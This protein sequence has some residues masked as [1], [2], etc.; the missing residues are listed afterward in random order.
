MATSKKPAEY[1]VTASNGRVYRITAADDGQAHQLAGWIEDRI[2]AGDDDLA[3]DV[4]PPLNTQVL[5]PA[6]PDIEGADY[7]NTGGLEG[8]VSGEGE[9][10][11]DRSGVIGGIDSF[12]RGATRTAYGN[13]ADEIAAGIDAVLPISRLTGQPVNSIWDGSSLSDAYEHNLNLQRQIDEADDTQHPVMS[14]TGKVGGA[15]L[16]AIGAGKLLKAGA[17][18]VAPMLGKTAIGPVAAAEAYQLAHPVKAA[19]IAGGA[20]GGLSGAFGGSGEGEDAATRIDNAQR[21]GATGLMFGSALAPVAVSLAPA[22]ARYANV[23]FGRMPER[24]ATQ[25]LI[26]ALQRDGYDITSPTGVKALRDE[27]GAYLGKP[28]S[29]ADI[30]IATRSRAGVG[31]RSPSNVQNK[32]VDLV[33]ARQAGQNIRL[34]SDIRATVAPRTDVHALDEALV[35]AREEEALPLRDRAL[36][37]TGGGF[38]DPLVPRLPTI[39]RNADAAD[40]GVMRTL[41]N[42]VPETYSPVVK[43]GTD[44]AEGTGRQARIPDDPVLQQIARLPFAQRALKAA[45][46]LAQ[47]E[48]NLGTVLGNDVSHLPD[49]TADGANLDMR[50]LDYLKRFLDKEVS[51]LGRQ[52]DSNTFS[53]AEYP[54]VKALRDALRTRMREVVPEY[55]D[56]LDSY[57]GSSD[58]IDALKE[59]RQFNQLDP[60]L[61]AKTQ[62]A[63]GRS[64]AEKELY[65]VGV[66]RNLLDEI[67]S[68]RDGS[69]AASRILNSDEARAQ[70]A[71][72]GVAPQDAARLERSVAIERQFNLLP[73][74]LSGNA[75]AAR[76]TA[77][78]D[79]DAG[80]RAQLP[81][82]PGSPLG[83]AGAAGRAVLNRASTVRNRAVNEALLPQILETNPQAID[84]IISD[85]ERAGKYADAAKL[86]RAKNTYAGTA[87]LGNLLGTGS[88]MQE[89]N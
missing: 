16:Q 34:A 61:I 42:D 79:A 70:L 77:T 41:G 23:L 52:A 33:H 64:T 58:L 11:L 17:T 44:V 43:S 57:R 38:G 6:R 39:T 36:F 9:R 35:K 24:E 29:L 32:M 83:W 13:Y 19:V 18:T 68:A 76:N 84:A 59:G 51:K 30:G 40:A 65:R 12:L 55:G 82:N 25:Q 53:A 54:Q 4:S 15:I 73:A 69:N 46:G 86:R 1:E 81:F 10:Q 48:V 66:A 31:L 50:T 26:Q 71:A 21:G 28:V 87:A 22:I 74:E 78:V 60:E 63:V 72:T 80:A 56:Y 62:N 3:G 5:K 45:R 2:A 88:A 14:N 75:S 37:E 67:S 89:G 27:L 47:E 20:G 7:I 8:Q 49:V 85:L